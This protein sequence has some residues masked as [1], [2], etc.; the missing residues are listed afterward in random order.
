MRVTSNSFPSTLTAQL[1][2]LQQKQLKYQQ[3]SATG[4]RITQSSDDPLGFQRAQVRQTQLSSNQSYLDTTADAQT[5][6]EYNH[7]A[8]S[9]LQTALSRA[10]EIATKVSG[11]YDA[12]DLLAMSE[13]ID[14][15]LSQ[16]VL[17]SNRQKDGAQLFGGTSGAK[18]ITVS[19]ST[20]DFSGSTNSSVTQAQIA[21]AG[22]PLNTGL[23]AGRSPLNNSTSA[24]TYDGFL[25]DSGTSTDTLNTLIQLRDTLAAANA[26]TMTVDQVATAVQNTWLPG[27]NKSV[28]LA[29][30][31]VGVTAAS[32][33][34]LSLNKTT[35]TNQV[36]VDKEN[37]SAVTNV[38][39]A[40]A[41]TNLQ[42]TQTNYEAALQA[43]AKILTLSLMD[44][45]K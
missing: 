15:I 32:L 34:S 24:A 10:S 6:C 35:L 8:M 2:D 14:G 16:V 40:E 43:G 33:E 37:M 13:D 31:Y 1:Q 26:G 39:L 11:I 44:Y 42:Q 19:G 9:D 45:L 38:N 5:L 29:S 30:R 21:A 25:Y 23:V 20:Y 28:D 12:N 4:L 27:I 7:Q 3:Q 36:K 17:I 18:P 41:L 22:T